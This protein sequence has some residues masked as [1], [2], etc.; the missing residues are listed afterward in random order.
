MK[1]CITIDPKY[2]GDISYL[3]TLKERNDKIQLPM[4]CDEH[5]P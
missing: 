4:S 2:A 5:P 3:T 1:K